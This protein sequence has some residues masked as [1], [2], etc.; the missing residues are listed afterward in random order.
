MKKDAFPK[1][2]RIALSWFRAVLKFTYPCL[3]SIRMY[4][5]AVTSLLSLVDFWRW[6]TKYSCHIKLVQVVLKLFKK[7]FNIQ[8]NTWAKMLQL[9]RTE[10]WFQT[11]DSTISTSIN[12]ILLGVFGSLIARGEADLPAPWFFSWIQLNSVELSWTQKN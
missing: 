8:K 7:P 1:N 12:P 2:G 10:A 4:A 11:I 6:V 9:L 3:R 5:W